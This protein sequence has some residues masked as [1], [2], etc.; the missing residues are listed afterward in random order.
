MGR[1]NMRAARD[2]VDVVAIADVDAGHAALANKELSEGKASVYSDYRK[3]LERKDLDAIHVA[4]PDHWHTKTLIEAMLAGFD[5]YCEK[6]LT[7]TIDE[8]KLIRKIQQETDRIVQVGTQQ[9]SQFDLF[10]KAIALVEAGRLGR[11]QRI[12]TRLGKGDTSSPQ[13][14]VATVPAELDW[15]RWLG[16]APSTNYRFLD[17]KDPRPYTNCH[18]EFRWWYQYSGGKL[19]DWGAHHIDIAM[20]ALRVNNQSP[21]SMTIT[22]EA[23][24]K[25]PFENGYPT[26]DDRYNTAVDFQFDV[27]TSDGTEI[28]LRSEGDNGVLIE[29][30][31][32]RIFVNRGRLTGKPVEDLADNPLPENASQKAYKNHPIVEDERKAHWYNFLHCLRER[33]EPISDVASH[34]RSLN[35]C[36]LAAI[37]GRLGREL[38][39]DVANEQ[40]VGDEEA[41]AFLR[42]EYRKGYEIEA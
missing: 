27:V 14:P 21:D 12:E 26:Q 8:G 2:W 38:H 9:R 31:K 42:R 36:H 16:P 40:I 24:H 4:T 34:M 29:G 7:L 18:Y 23:S 19:T 13:V 39:W 6:P 3:L 41:N 30:D 25:V 22:G 35:V 37:C 5:V 17:R 32:G 33:A 1:G 20:W 15:D 10:V 11:I 28:A